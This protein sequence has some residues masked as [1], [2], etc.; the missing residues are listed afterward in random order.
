MIK[1]MLIKAKPFDRTQFSLKGYPL[2]YNIKY[3]ENSIY[4]TLISFFI[5]IF[6]YSHCF[7]S[8]VG[9]F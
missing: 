2:L 9:H 5:F 3:A 8:H 6:I 7:Y 1:P 4:V